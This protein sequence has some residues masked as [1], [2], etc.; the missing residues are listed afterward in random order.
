MRASTA[1][2]IFG[3]PDWTI[4]AKRIAHLADQN[5]NGPLGLYMI[6]GKSVIIQE[7]AREEDGFQVYIAVAGNSVN[8]VR[9]A[10]G[11]EY[12]KPTLE[13]GKTRCPAISRISERQ[14]IKEIGHLIAHQWEPANG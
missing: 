7:Y 13:N 1:R 6:N 14:C 12:V 8:D 11:I 2:K 4:E 10:I 3:H 9:D 5:I